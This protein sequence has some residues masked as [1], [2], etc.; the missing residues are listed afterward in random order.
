MASLSTETAYDE[1]PCEGTANGTAGAVEPPVAGGFVEPRGG[2]ALLYDTLPTPI[3]ELLLV[4]DG[5][6]VTGVHMDV[7]HAWTPRVG[8]SWRRDRRIL[9]PVADQLRAYLAG[10]L[11]KF[12][13]ALAPRGTRFQLRVW[14]ALLDIPYGSTASYAEV[15]RS[16][17]SPAATR[18]VG[19]ANGR[20]PIAVIV[21]CHRVIGSDGSLTGYGGGLARK[22]SLLDL[23]ARSRAAV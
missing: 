12:D 13:L 3:G 15:A 23:E 7:S 5:W 19:A 16:I 18:A 2:C 21:P 20:N 14:S 6:A 22:R 1:R 8:A 4:S 11:T 10:E 17:G 9:S